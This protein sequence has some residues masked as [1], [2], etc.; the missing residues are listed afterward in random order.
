V[1]ATQA[2][3]AEATAARVAA[4]ANAEQ[5]RQALAALPAP[6]EGAADD[7]AQVVES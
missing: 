7:A 2:E 5:Q 3:L 1:A 4:S 6:P